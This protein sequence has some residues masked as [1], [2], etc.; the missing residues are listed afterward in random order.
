MNKKIISF[1]LSINFVFTCFMQASYA[2]VAQKGFLDCHEH[3]A[4]DEI[5]VLVESGIVNGRGGNRFC[6][7]SNITRAEFLSLIVK[8]INLDKKAYNSAFS[9]VNAGDWYAEIVQAAYD[10]GLINVGMVYDGAFRGEQLITR[11]EMASLIIAGYQFKTGKEVQIA[12]INRFEDV[13]QISDWAVDDVKKAVFLG[14]VTGVTNDELRPGENATRAQ[15]AVMVFRLISLSSNNLLNGSFDEKDAS[16]TYAY[17]TSA[18]TKTYKNAEGTVGLSYDDGYY[19]PGCIFYDVKYSGKWYVNA[20]QWNCVLG[21]DDGGN[22]IEEGKTYRL[23]FWAKLE[24]IDSFTVNQIAMRNVSNRDNIYCEVQSANI[25]GDSWRYYQIYMTATQSAGTVRLDF[26][27]GGDEKNNFKL[28]MDDFCLEEADRKHIPV[29]IEYEEQLAKYVDVSTGGTYL[30]G[31]EVN[32]FAA[33]RQGYDYLFDTWVDAYGNEI[34]QNSLFTVTAEG[35]KNMTATF[36]PYVV[37]GKGFDVAASEGDIPEVDL[38]DISI[39]NG[40]ALISGS[41]SIPEGYT[42]LD[43]GSLAYEGAYAGKFNVFTDAVSVIGADTVSKTGEFNVVVENISAHSKLILRSYLICTDAE[44]RRHV[45]YSDKMVVPPQESYEKKDYNLLYNHELLVTFSK[46]NV[47]SSEHFESYISELTA[48]DVDAVTCCP[49]IWRTQVWNSEVDPSISMPAH[50]NVTSSNNEYNRAKSYILS[51]GDVVAETLNACHEYGIDFIGSFRMNDYHYTDDKGWPTHNYFWQEHPEYW[52]Y[53]SG[54]NLWKRLFNYMIPE[55]RDFYY[56]LIEEFVSLYDVDG[57]EL[58]FH[59]SMMYF[60]P[61]EAEQGLEVMTELVGKVRDMLDKVG[62]ERGKYLQLSVKVPSTLEECYEKGLDVVTWD[63]LGYVDIVNLSNG[64][65]NSTLFDVE[66][67]KESLKNSRLHVEMTWLTAQS[68]NSR[69]YTTIEGYY[70]TA[71]NLLARGADGLSVW[72]IGWLMTSKQPVINALRGITDLQHLNK[73]EKHYVI[74][75][76]LGIFP[77]T[78]EKEFDFYVPDDTGSG[79]YKSS[80]FRVEMEKDCTEETIEVCI[81]GVKLEQTVRDD[82]ILFTKVMENDTG[83]ANPNMV[84]FY[85][86][87]LDI[88]KQGNNKFHIKVV[89]QDKAGQILSAELALY[90]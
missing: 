6:P 40:T 49:G 85:D 57:I 5:N 69:R 55:V 44:Q 28:Y 80:V 63:R 56:R 50:P 29:G 15:A 59:R 75:N 22:V 43:C 73:M 33:V 12:E 10:S 31:E 2:S 9:D 17:R 66:G 14:I 87:P 60:Y 46:D 37:R 72:N 38:K 64:D 51:G 90:H 13:H 30:E 70:G 7:D 41:V 18:T 71:H 34:E 47:F 67:F 84:K 88:L 26:W 4:E 39:N 23:S 24:G 82:S 79:I 8:T 65:Y 77:A 61:E 81:N 52:F 74:P 19:N 16:W 32:L 83:Y 27:A 53:D 58:D 54:V 3:W 89:S 68:G 86:V 76:K 35:N 11:E 42:V 48:S 45:F 25:S 36:Q 62:K 78:T 1:L 20:L 21:N